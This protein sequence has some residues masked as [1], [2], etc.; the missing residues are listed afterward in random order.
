ME[1]A[2]QDKSKHMEDDVFEEQYDAHQDFQV[3]GVGDKTKGGVMSLQEK[4]NLADDVNEE[5]SSSED[6][7]PNDA[8]KA[9]Y[10]SV[11]PVKQED[12]LSLATA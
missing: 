4:M 1:I 3:F 8:S 7:G 11:T 10:S 5:D 12:R 2:N 9:A 6:E